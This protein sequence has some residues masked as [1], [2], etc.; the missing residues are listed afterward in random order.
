MQTAEHTRG[1]RSGR[2]S[3]MVGAVVA[4]VRAGKSPVFVVIHAHSFRWYIE[5]LFREQAPDIPFATNT[6]RFV[7]P[8]DVRRGAFDGYGDIDAF[9]DHY[10]AGVE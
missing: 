4:A 5:T 1:R 3:R 8:E 9:W 6:L 10:A 7:T 2:T